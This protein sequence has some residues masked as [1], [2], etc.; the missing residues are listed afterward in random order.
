MSWHIHWDPSFDLARGG[1]ELSFR[2]HEDM[3]RLLV[4]TEAVRLVGRILDKMLTPS[5]SSRYH[6]IGTR[7]YGKSTILNYVA[8]SLFSN[9]SSRRILPVYSSLLGK[10]TTEQ[11]LEFIFF[12]SLLESLFH[13]PSDIDDFHL[14][15]TFHDVSEHLTAAK[16]EYKQQLMTLGQVTLEYVYTAFENQ[17]DHLKKVFQKI[18]FLVDGL[19]KQETEIVLRFLRNT[20][21]RLNMLITKY[22]C[23]FMDAADPSWRENLDTKEFKGVRGFTIN[24]RGWTVDEI[25]ALIKNRLEMMG[26]FLVPFDR[27]AL[28]IVIEDFQGNPREILQYCTTLLHYAA[29]EHIETIGPGLARKIVWNDDAKERFFKFVIGDTDARYGFEKLKLIYN[30][31]QIMNI[32]IATF[33]N[34]GQRL[35]RNLNYEARSSV[36]IT[37][38]DIDY[39]K[40]LD[41]LLAKGCFKTSKAQNYLELENDLKKLFDFIEKMNQSLIALPVVLGE[42]EFKIEESAPPLKEEI[43]VKE[44]IQKVFEQNSNKWLDYT[45]CKE[46]L[47]A[48]PRTKSKLEEHF[49]ENYQQKVASTIPLVVHNL[50]NTGKLMQDEETAE[51]RWR[52]STIDHETADF[53]KSKVILDLIDAVKKS[54]AEVDMQKIGAL[55]DKMFSASFSKLNTLFGNRVDPNNIAEAI[56]FLKTLDVNVSRPIPLHMF[57]MSL[58]EKINNSDEGNVCAESTI[59]YAKRIFTKFNQLNHHEPKNQEK[60]SQLMR[61]KTGSLKE[62]EREHFKKFLMPWLIKNYGKMIECMTSAKTKCGYIEKVHAELK[63]LQENGQILPAEILR[64]PK[65]NREMASEKGTGEAKVRY[66]TEDKVPYEYIKS[67]YILSS[68]TYEAWNVWME[69]YSKMILEKLPC[70]YIETGIVLKP[71]EAVGVSTPEEVDLVLVYNGKLIAIEC[72]ENVQMTEEKNDVSNIIHKIENLGIFDFVVLVYQHVDDTSRFEAFVKKYKKI[73]STVMIKRSREFSADLHQVLKS[74]A[75][76]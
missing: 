66:C 54:I 47:V 16:V 49:G 74:V 31:R 6:V 29:K 43:A 67:A 36:G 60:I 21:E 35:S 20:Q 2:I 48:N 71:Y 18:I 70:R 22:N 76:I 23:V 59:L 26:I 8:Y 25:E 44:E 32:L 62:E 27:K 11:E 57:L 28:E 50:L 19:D 37:L 75:E 1:I 15:E 56:A 58:K 46:L 17:L 24:L 12:R 9:L 10:A 65:C 30:E 64:C 14:S 73:L 51:Y 69:E 38:S 61:C 39:Q 45:Q 53:F 55:C 40:N 42:L 4:E 41:M 33:S 34:K 7:G 63:N 68:K 52:P 5:V 3:N 72:M 13:V